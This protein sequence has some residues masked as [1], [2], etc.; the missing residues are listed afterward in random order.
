MT[1][2]TIK[3]KTHTKC[4]KTQHM[5]YFWNPD[6]LLIPNMMIDTSP[7]PSCS[8]QSPWLPCSGHTIISTGPSVSPFRD[9]LPGIRNDFFHSILRHNVS[10]P[11]IS[12]SCKK[13]VYHFKEANISISNK[14]YMFHNIEIDINWSGLKIIR[15]MI[16]ANRTKSGKERFILYWFFFPCHCTR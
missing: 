6:D 11:C 5:L 12:F 3:T 8:S 7:W 16:R 2:T 15:G 13:S 4:L 14:I 10:G 1:K 9:F